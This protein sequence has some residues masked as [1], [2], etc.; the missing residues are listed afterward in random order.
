M[1][2]SADVSTAV[3]RHDLVN[4]GKPQPRSFGLGR[5]KWIEDFAHL[6]FRKAFASIGKP[7]ADL[8]IH[9]IRSDR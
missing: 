3:G 5:K 7:N 2:S 4:H 6:F 9:H 1:G 8:V